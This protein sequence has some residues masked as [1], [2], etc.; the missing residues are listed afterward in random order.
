MAFKKKAEIYYRQNKLE[1]SLKTYENLISYY[2][3][4]EKLLKQFDLL[5]TI[6]GIHGLLKN[7]QQTIEIYIKA[8]K[9]F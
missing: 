9:Q 3:P 6:G 7:P 2:K 4:N 5:K 8:L 1:E